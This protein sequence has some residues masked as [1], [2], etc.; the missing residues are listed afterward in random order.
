MS[1]SP[2]DCDPEAEEDEE[3]ELEERLL[4]SLPPS[5]SLELGKYLQL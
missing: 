4:S 1:D 3:D 2:E 5:L